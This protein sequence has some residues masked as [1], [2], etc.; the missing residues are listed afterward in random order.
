MTPNKLLALLNSL[1]VGELDSIAG[2]IEQAKAG[3]LEIGESDLA[4]RLDEA[5]EAL[6]GLDMTT[7]RKRIETVVSKLGHLR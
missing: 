2:K 4:T 6:D 5:L 7:Y 1:S 3:C